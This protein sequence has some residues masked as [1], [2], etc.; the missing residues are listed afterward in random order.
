MRRNFLLLAILLFALPV[1]SQDLNARVQ[2]LAPQLSNSNKRVF[3]IL[4]TSIRDFLNSRR[5]STDVLQSQERIDCNFV[6]TINDWDGS[7]SFK[8]E[9]QIQSSRPIYGTTY[10]STILNISDKDFNFNYTEGQPLDYT[11]QNYIS[12]LT[13][14]LAY[15]AYV[16]TGLDNDTFSKMGGTP[17]YN[18][19]QSI[20][21][22]AQN[23][24]NAGWKAFEGLRNRY[25]LTENLLNKTYNPIR[26]ALYEFHLNGLDVMADN[27]SKGRKNIYSLLPQLQ[28]IDKQKQGAM[29]PQL[30]FTAKY[31]EFVNVL[32]NAA[33]QDKIKA[34]NIL[35]EIDPANTSKYEALKKAQQ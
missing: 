25:W 19:A 14:L 16:I 24:P 11:D 23:A 30:F 17:Y 8:A 21:N 22:F 6:I 31:D 29:L 15:Y 18:K 7:N 27:Q 20:V 34:Y 3:D 13:S 1:F 12:N 32:I 26:E 4:E 5:W 10:N 9:A 35:S 28:K 33:P 2:V